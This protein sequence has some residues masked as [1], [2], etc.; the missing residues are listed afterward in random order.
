MVSRQKGS[1]ITV[2]DCKNR[3]FVTMM[4]IRALFVANAKYCLIFATLFKNTLDWVNFACII[5][6][7]I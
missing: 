7:A 1:S 6:E 4:K 3:N 2:I 5:Y